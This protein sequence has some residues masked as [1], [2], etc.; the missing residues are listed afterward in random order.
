MLLLKQ[1]CLCTL[2]IAL[3]YCLP[4]K[5]QDTLTIT[6]AEQVPFYVLRTLVSTG[7]PYEKGM[8]IP[9][10]GLDRNIVK[11]AIDQKF[12]PKNVTRE[13]NR[14]GRGRSRRRRPCSTME[15]LAEFIQAGMCNEPVFAENDAPGN[16]DQATAEVANSG[17]VVADG[18]VQSVS[19]AAN[20]QN[21]NADAANPQTANADAANPQTANADAANPQT[22]NADAANPQNANADAAN[23]QTAN[24][25]A[26]NGMVENT[27][28]VGTGTM[29]T[30]P[31]QPG[32]VY[33]EN[34]GGNTPKDGFVKIEP[35]NEPDY[36]IFDD[37][38]Y[39][40]ISQFTSWTIT[41]STKT[42]TAT[43]T[44]STK[45]T[46]TDGEIDSMDSSYFSHSFAVVS[47]VGSL[48]LY[49]IIGV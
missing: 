43:S 12:I 29:E 3:A 11:W 6:V 44:N 48:F 14:N 40:S 4:A 24:A 13:I 23:T 2:V 42:K 37:S 5:C 30:T 9:G 22:A 20:P 27:G 16:A 10:L 25:D 15:E 1:T 32:V 35:T 18:N 36:R 7:D 28:S 46:S 39:A 34:Q 33:T 47:F 19:D 26:P 49:A 17:M 38:Y 21:A 31:V 45:T 8:S 41:N